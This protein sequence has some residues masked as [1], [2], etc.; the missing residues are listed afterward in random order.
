MGLQPTSAVGR[1]KR[2]PLALAAESRYV[3]QTIS[4]GW[5]GARGRGSRVPGPGTRCP[6]ART[7]LARLAFELRHSRTA[8]CPM[9]APSSSRPLPA[10]RCASL[11]RLPRRSR[12]AA[13]RS[14]PAHGT[15]APPVAHSRCVR[16]A[17]CLPR[18]LRPFLHLSCRGPSTRGAPTQSNGGPDRASPAFP[19]TAPAPA[20][21]PA[22]RRRHAPGISPFLATAVSPGRSSTCQPDCRG[23]SPTW[24]CS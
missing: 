15:G 6:M 22:S 2:L 17:H 19:A 8:P 14:S 9:S 16:G 5:V 10:P 20:A 12:T 7:A 21:E 11:V 24:N 4:S 13:S 1:R 23:R 3:G 18:S